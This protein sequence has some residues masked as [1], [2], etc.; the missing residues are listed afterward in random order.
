MPG[1]ERLSADLQSGKWQDQHRDLL[2]LE[3]LD[4]GYRLIVADRNVYKQNL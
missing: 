4:L 2:T 1:L 3:E